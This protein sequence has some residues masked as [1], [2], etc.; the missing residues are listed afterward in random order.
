LHDALKGSDWLQTRLTSNVTFAKIG[1]HGGFCKLL[2]HLTVGSWASLTRMQRSAPSSTDGTEE[3]LLYMNLCLLGL[4]QF[5]AK[6]AGVELSR[7]CFRKPNPKA[8]EAVL[9]GLHSAIHGEQ[10]TAKV[11]TQHVQQAIQQLGW[12][13]FDGSGFAL[14]HPAGVQEHLAH[15]GQKPEQ[16]L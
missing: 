15:H 13:E 2:K 7:Q 1:L 3:G 4:P 6:S 16:G 10:R 5:A 9:Y 8:L 14:W 11:H 12:K